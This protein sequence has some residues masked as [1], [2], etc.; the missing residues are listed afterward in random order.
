LRLPALALLLVM[1]L[2]SG[3]FAAPPEP[4]P[5][6]E[7]IRIA[8]RVR[9][10][11]TRAP[12]ID[13][14]IMVI[15]A[16][17]DV[18]PGA[19]A[20]TPLDPD[21]D[22]IEWIREGRSDE[23]GRFEIADVPRGKVRVVVVSPGHE[24]LEV[25]AEAS[26]DAKE[27]L[28]F[29][30]PGDEDGFRTEVVSER[31]IELPR[32]E[33][34]VEGER[35]RVYPGTAGDP[36]RAVQNLPGVARAPGGLGLV[37][38]R[39][40]DPRQTGIYV[41]GH[42]VPRAFHVLPLAAVV[43]PSMV[44]AVELTPGNYDAAYGG[45][46]GGLLEIHTRP[47][48]LF[49]EPNRAIHGEAHLDLFDVGGAFRGP[50][51]PGAVAF[52]FRRS[53][54]GEVL[55]A[56]D[57]LIGNT[58]LL[59]PNYWDYIARVDLPIRRRHRLTL[60]AFGAGDSL[61]DTTEYIPGEPVE[62]DFSSAFHRFDLGYEFAD[63]RT[64][65]GLSA[66]LLLDDSSVGAEYPSHRNGW[67]FSLRAST[68]H[69]WTR[70]MTLLAGLDLADVHARRR[71]EYPD[72]PDYPD[73]PESPEAGD[74]SE[75]ET[76]HYRF[77]TWLGVA[78][79]VSPRPGPLIIRPQVRL[80][81]F[82]TSSEQRLAVD[83]RLDLRW[84]VHRRIELFAALGRYSSPSKVY[85][86]GY[87][88]IERTFTG[89]AII[90]VPDWLSAYFDPG[91]EQEVQNGWLVVQHTHHA[92]LGAAIALPWALTLRATTFWRESLAAVRAGPRD[93]EEPSVDEPLTDTTF[94]VPPTRAYG[95][96]FL[97]DR[98]LGKSIHGLI[99][100]TLLRARTKGESWQY[101]IEADAEWLPTIFDQRHNLVA[102]AIFELPRNF[103]LGA[104]FRAV[105]GNP[106]ER[107]IG[108]VVSVD[109]QGY[110]Y[111]PI[112][113]KLG[114]TYAP[115]FHQLDIRIDKTWYA[116]RFL[117]VGYVDIQNVYN[118]LYPEI[119]VYSRDWT[120]RSSRLGL[121]IFPSFGLRIEI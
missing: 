100:Y 121:P 110:R 106:E 107:V 50:V 81:V 29:L 46:A 3:V 39:G 114:S 98:T 28:L 16:P 112:R 96:E 95:L 60:K 99:G 6:I 77:G 8:G 71:T 65:A 68:S 120:E 75:Y 59:V 115:P 57:N 21:S 30:E 58:G 53:H 20:R 88:G 85:G 76:H 4:T 22:S 93:W 5:T 1:G 36:V 83:P 92:S 47:G 38:I 9:V 41:D 40:G 64:R 51:G 42:P 101:S 79:M 116:K 82:G 119:W 14:K 45:H 72:Y 86:G 61:H 17:D 118:N 69:R 52:A 111:S 48:P 15:E 32:A 26:A 117:V 90:D 78:F 37:A 33:H 2:P 84:H 24:R 19:V 105:S 73:Y 55:Q 94:R 23:D 102:L 91:D 67:T 109:I 108:T 18:R 31:D 56:A 113:G 104:R 12:V 87:G 74:A 89:T 70:H 11:G 66:A 7:S 27:L 49:G 10:A 63:P 25:W 44:E 13:A 80:N 35:A 43:S 62:I 103:R 54:V 97:L 34:R